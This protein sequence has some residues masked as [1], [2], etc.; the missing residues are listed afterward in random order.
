M[1]LTFAPPRLPAGSQKSGNGPILFPRLIAFTRSGPPTIPIVS[2]T[3]RHW[4][5]GVPGQGLQRVIRG[6]AVQGQAATAV[7]TGGEPVCVQ[8]VLFD[9][10]CQGP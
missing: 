8:R 10:C 1:V 3:Y 6:N 4:L 9:R 2:V 5:Q 7:Q